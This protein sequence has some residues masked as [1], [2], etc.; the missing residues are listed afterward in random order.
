VRDAGDPNA[1][2]PIDV[3]IGLQDG[4]H[5]STHLA[6]VCGNPAKPLSRADQLEKFHRNCE[7]A[8]RPV[9]RKRA[10]QLIARVA[11]LEEA[12]DIGELLQLIA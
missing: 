8:A 12:T 7:A 4:S 11:L 5:C 1:L 10:E 3:E 9:P 2:T 6:T